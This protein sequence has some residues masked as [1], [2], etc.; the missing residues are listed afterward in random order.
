MTHHLLE[1]AAMS[2]L[3]LALGMALIGLLLLGIAMF[4]EMW[5]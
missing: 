5:K 2:F 1:K 3:L 4:K